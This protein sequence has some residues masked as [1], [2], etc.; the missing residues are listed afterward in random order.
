MSFYKH[1][2]ALVESTEIGEG[3]R[4]WAFAHVMPGAVI[5]AHCNI[6]D[7]AFVESGVRMGDH[8]T[9]KN[10]VAVWDCVTLEDNVFVG[11][12]AVFTND[13]NPRAAVKKTRE[14]FL[15]TLVRYGAS[16]GAN[17]TLVCGV[18]V[19][20]FAFVGAGTV[21][22][23]D[24]PDHVMVVGNPARKIG[25]MCECGEKLPASLSCKCGL[26]FQKSGEGLARA[27]TAGSSSA[28]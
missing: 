12:N 1:P 11:P 23:R 17:C 28:R 15:P 16:L 24:V 19:G 5:G 13:M 8:V 25:F 14:Q 10:G 7:H 21:V 18:T 22:H 27:V 9:I 3:T 4:V 20:R 6:G 2:N 26:S